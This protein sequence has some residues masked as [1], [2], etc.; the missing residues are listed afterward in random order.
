MQVERRPTE[1]A[2]HVKPTRA[3]AWLRLGGAT[4]NTRL[5]AVTG[6]VLLVLLAVEGATLVSLQTFLSWHIFVGMLLV[7]IVLLKIGSTAYRFV[8]YYSKQRDYVAAGAPHIVLR[9]LGPIVV[10]ST[11]G[12]FSS[13]VALAALGPGRPLVLTLHQA[14]FVVWV[15]AM[16]LHV[17]GHIRTVPVLATSDMRGRRVGGARIRAL[18]LA[19]AIV[20]GA[21]VA[22]A[23]VPWIGPWIHAAR[24]DG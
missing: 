14:S 6:L 3:R 21:V 7:P 20:T 22:V 18:L 24:F 16:S 23:T 5:T 17:L 4:G 1:I 15:G 8:R 13:G 12:L 19:A 10:A 2:R 11:I 9:L